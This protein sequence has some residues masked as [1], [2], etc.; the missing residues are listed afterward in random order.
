L[1]CWHLLHHH[2]NE[3]RWW[4]WPPTTVTDDN[5]GAQTMTTW[6]R[7]NM[8]LLSTTIITLP[9]LLK[10]T[11]LLPNAYLFPKSRVAKHP[12]EVMMLSSYMYL[13]PSTLSKVCCCWT[14][15]YIQQMLGHHASSLE[16][17]Q[18]HGT[19]LLVASGMLANQ[20]KD[21]LL[22]WLCQEWNQLSSSSTYCVNITE[23]GNPNMLKRQLHCLHQCN[24]SQTSHFGQ[25]FY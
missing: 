16:T 9:W 22:I 3:V 20:S 15:V 11:R 23:M 7:D 10:R 13:M 21:I 14:V 12:Y 4:R 19:V 2:R 8:P 18:T 6:Q 17:T 1:H 24:L 25:S 5:A